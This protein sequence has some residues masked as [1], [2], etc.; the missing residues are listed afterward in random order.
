MLQ[1]HRPRRNITSIQAGR[2]AAGG[3]RR[4]EGHRAFEWVDPT[5]VER[6]FGKHTG[7]PRL[8]KACPNDV[9]G[10]RLAARQVRGS[11]GPIEPACPKEAWPGPASDRAGRE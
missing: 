6:H 11:S 5:I 4:P 9:P 8:T 2:N 1:N 10:G 7:L 3:E